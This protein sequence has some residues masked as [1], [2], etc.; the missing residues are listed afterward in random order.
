ERGREDTIGGID[1][2][3][4][5]LGPVAARVLARLLGGT[6][7]ELVLARRGL[8]GGH[9]LVRAL[10]AGG[11]LG[12]SLLLLVAALVGI[13]IGGLARSLVLLVVL[14]LGIGRIGLRLLGQ[15]IAQA[16]I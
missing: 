9:V 15:R 4:Q 16:E 3:R 7:L 14:A 2:G 8:L 13:A 10:L 6:V 1:A 11:L 12:R 5:L